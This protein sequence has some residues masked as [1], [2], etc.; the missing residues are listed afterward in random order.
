[1][2][3]DRESA[4]KISLAVWMLTS[5]FYFAKKAEKEKA[6][7]NSETADVNTGV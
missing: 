1:M 4:N 5:D 3:Y 6:E 2:N 7:K